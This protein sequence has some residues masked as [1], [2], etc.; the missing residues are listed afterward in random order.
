MTVLVDPVLVDPTKSV[1]ISII[2]CV[3]SNQGC[4]HIFLN[5]IQIKNK[6]LLIGSEGERSQVSRALFAFSGSFLYTLDNTP[7][8]VAI[9]NIEFPFEAY[10]NHIIKTSQ[11]YFHNLARLRSVLPGPV[12]ETS[13]HVLSFLCVCMCHVITA[14]LSLCSFQVLFAVGPNFFRLAFLLA[15][16]LSILLQRKINW[17]LIMRQACGAL[18][19]EIQLFVHNRISMVASA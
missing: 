13:I 15:L 4:H 9:V 10:I 6:T 19:N 8:L 18:T 17:V 14:L 2:I 11:Q 12:S 7:N 5:I 3:I 16:S 1:I